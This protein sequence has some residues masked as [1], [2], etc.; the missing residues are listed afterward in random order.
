MVPGERRV[1]L[2][3]V[4]RVQRTQGNSRHLVA[5]AYYLL[6]ALWGSLG[7][8]VAIVD[9]TLII[10][11]NYSAGKTLLLV[12]GAIACVGYLRILQRRAALK[13]GDP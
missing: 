12:V 4:G 5:G 10:E 2:W 8:V 11:N 9:E 13:R 1:A 7:S 6:A 3:A